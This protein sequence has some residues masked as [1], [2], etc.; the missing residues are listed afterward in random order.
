MTPRLVVCRCCA[1]G[2]AAY[3]CCTVCEAHPASDAWDR[4]VASYHASLDELD[5]DDRA[6]DVAQAHELECS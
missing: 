5:A 3:A 2:K 1:T 6:R 4:L